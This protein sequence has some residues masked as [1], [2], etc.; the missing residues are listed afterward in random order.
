MT[1]TAL[2]SEQQPHASWRQLLLVFIVALLLFSLMRLQPEPWLQAQISQQSRQHGI[3]LQ[4]HALQIEGF[5]VHFDQFKVQTSQLP[6]PIVLDS[7][8]LSP[9]WSSL[10]TGTIAIQ[11]DTSWQGQQATAVVSKQGDVIDVQS[12]N[13]LLETAA[14]QPLLAKNIPIPV[15]TSGQIQ[16]TGT[17]LLNAINAHP[18][19]GQIDITW[20]SAAV[21]MASMKT[22]LGD[23]KLS[24]QN[25]ETGTPWQWNIDGG[26]T[27]LLSSKGSIATS[28]MQPERWPLNGQIR[29][30][31][32]K[33]PEAASLAALLGNQAKQFN[34]SGTLA[35]PNLRPF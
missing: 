13:A 12:F 28:T 14:L 6:A 1:T 24:L 27:L 3:T 16:A 23:Y 34:I 30:E 18:L 33:K 5:T 35:S 32:G 8:S 17:L 31:V 2:P 9:A 10:L 11:L 21:E 4:Y 15:K 19:N 25:S 22:P 20:S 29:I 7:L 26:S